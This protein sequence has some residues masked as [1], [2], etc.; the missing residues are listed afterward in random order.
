MGHEKTET[1][2]VDGRHYN[3]PMIDSGGAKMT[4]RSAIQE[5]FHNNPKDKGYTT[6]GEAVDAARK[7]SKSFDGSK[8]DKNTRRK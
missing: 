1:F 8:Y 3:V 2:E 7:R 5:H 4:P 6:Q